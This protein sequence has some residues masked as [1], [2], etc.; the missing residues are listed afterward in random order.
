MEVFCHI[1]LESYRLEFVKSKPKSIGLDFYR[2]RLD[3]IQNRGPDQ[4]EGGEEE[5]EERKNRLGR[6]KKNQISKEEKKN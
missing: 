4:E 1:D 2:T 3:Q 5:V 6:K